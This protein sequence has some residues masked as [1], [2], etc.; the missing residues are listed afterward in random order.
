LRLV[1]F[2]DYEVFQVLSEVKKTSPESDQLPYWLF[3]ECAR[4]LCSVVKHLINVIFSTGICPA[5]WKRAFVT[6]IPK[7]N[8]PTAFSYF[9]TYICDLSR[10]LE[11]LNVRKFI[12]PA[13]PKTLCYD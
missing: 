10:L 9:K 13:L 4:L 3:P 2:T 1:L 5:S 6:P 11:R 7:I 8:Q 12:L